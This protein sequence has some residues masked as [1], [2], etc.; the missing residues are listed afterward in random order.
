MIDTT[1]NEEQMKKVREQNDLR[2]EVARQLS[3]SPK[4]EDDLKK[5]IPN[6]SYDQIANVLRNLLLLKLIKKEG[7]PVKYSLSEEIANRLLKRKELS[8]TDTNIIKVSMMIESMSNDKAA[9]RT[10]MESIIEQIKKDP[11]YFIYSIN[12]ADIGISND[13]FSTYIEG[14]LSCSGFK[15]L[16]KLIYFYG[17]TSID[18]LKPDK[19]T[20][21]ISELQEGLVT[22]VDLTHGY[23][24][25][26]Y[27][28][29][30]QVETLSNR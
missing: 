30:K 24:E 8:N 6:A 20:L 2:D 25:M 26:I 4:T 23:A 16:L 11:D 29:K 14:E 15:S 18:I 28:L 5:L 7:F 21:N 9:L 22:I 13:L 1:Y 17:V 27:K 3:K 10:G 19:L 12:L